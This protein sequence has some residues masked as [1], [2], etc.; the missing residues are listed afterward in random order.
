M[1][2]FPDLIRGY[3]SVLHR[4]RTGSQRGSL[5]IIR[6]DD[7]D[8]LRPKIGWVEYGAGDR[9][10]VERTVSSNRPPRVQRPVDYPRR[11]LVL[12]IDVDDHAR[13]ETRARDGVRELVQD[14]ARAGRAL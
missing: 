13:R 10:E 5:R 3:A 8:A 1:C 4:E 7:P 14:H 11:Y 12:D 6:I 2:L 9:L